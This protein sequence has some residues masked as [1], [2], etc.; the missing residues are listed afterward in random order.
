MCVCRSPGSG[1]EPHAASLQIP[2]EVHPADAEAARGEAGVSVWAEDGQRMVALHLRAERREDPCC[3]KTNTHLRIGVGCP[4]LTSLPKQSSW[5]DKLTFDA[6]LVTC[7]ATDSLC[8]EAWNDCHGLR[9]TWCFS[10]RGRWRCLWRSCRRRSTRRDRPASAETSPTWTLTWRS[11]S[12]SQTNHSPN[13]T[14][15][16]S[17]AVPPPHARRPETSFLWFTSP[18]KTLRF[19]LWRRFK[20]LILL[21]IVLFLVLLFLGVFLYSFP[22]SSGV[23]ANWNIVLWLKM[24]LIKP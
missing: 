4:Y 19:V 3:E 2:G 6:C 10:Y 23:N 12:E 17:N 7:V 18:Y 22:A 1:P 11:P 15:L 9:L 8:A 16:L 5:L 13:H 20:W 21:F 14:G 24:S